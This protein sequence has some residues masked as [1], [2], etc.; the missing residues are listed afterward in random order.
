[1][2]LLR[3]FLHAISIGL[4]FASGSCGQQLH[5]SLSSTS[6]RSNREPGEQ[7]TCSKDTCQKPKRF[8]LYDVNPGEG[9]NLR[10][11]V[12]LRAAVFVKALN[13]NDEKSEW[14]LVLPPWGP[15][16][17]WKRRDL[18]QEGLPWTLFFDLQSFNEYVPVMEFDDYLSERK[19]PVI[20]RMFYLLSFDLSKID[21][22]SEWLLE[23]TS[24]SE[25]AGFPY[26]LHSN[27]NNVRGWFWGFNGI[28]AKKITCHRALG[29]AGAVLP[30]L[31][32][33]TTP[34]DHAVMFERLETLLHDHFGGREYWEARRSMQFALPLL[35]LALDFR[36][37]H[38]LISSE[39]GDPLSARLTDWRTVKPPPGS[40]KGGPY[41][42][43]HLRRQDY[44]RAR[45]DACPSMKEAAEQ[46]RKVLQQQKVSTLFIA[47]DGSPDEMKELQTEL[48]KFSV[49]FYRPPEDVVR[50]IKDGGS[51]IV[52]QAICSRAQYFIGSYESTFSFRIQEERE[53]LG[54]APDSTFNRFC[55]TSTASCEQPTRWKIVY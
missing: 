23:E 25:E 11:D 38:G 14:T 44:L 13:V 31:L 54:F 24:C 21:L 20:D 16:Y 42:C 49:L 35:Q 33:Q 7:E 48:P 46:L 30:K 26:S 36:R 22:Q 51:A 19:E 55:K 6:W 52:E 1:M 5:G 34:K 3:I 18:N 12:Y 29:T 45:P 17:H 47:T 15:L 9:F 27:S 4:V 40:A 50:K 53:I 10:R 39:D 28:H 43:A 41:V 8:I 32:A 37:E 2:M